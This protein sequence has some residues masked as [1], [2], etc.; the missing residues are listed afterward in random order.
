MSKKEITTIGYL[1]VSTLEQDIEKNKA[2]ILKL[3]NS[4]NLGQ[5]KFIEEKIS[6]KITWKDRKLYEVFISLKKG[7]NIIVSELSR[8]GRSMLECMEILSISSKQGINI[9]AVKGDWKLNNSIQSKIIAMA[10]AMAAEIE[11][12]LISQRTK[13]ALRAI[14]AAGK[15]LGR[16][17][18]IGK[19]KLDQYAPEIKALIANGST[20][21]FIAN[22]YNTTE[23]N[24][25]HWL[26]NHDIKKKRLIINKNISSKYNELIKLLEQLYSIIEKL[27]SITDSAIEDNY[28]RFKYSGYQIYI[29]HKPDKTPNGT[30]NIILNCYF[31][32]IEPSNVFFQFKFFKGK[33]WS[34]KAYMFNMY[35][36]NQD[37][38]FGGDILPEEILLIDNNIEKE[39]KIDNFFK[40]YFLKALEKEIHGIR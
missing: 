29:K 1:R 39:R 9:Y 19:S 22:R 30:P 33:F 32:K 2:D 10:F 3:A 20:Q 13:E 21:K 26:K 6:G 27:S 36:R 40:K 5:V 23:A 8:L 24:L 25:H 18:G 15:K 11:R 37:I 16:P 31:L 38:L 12:D 28:F 4:Y 35:S 14:K 7:D 34:E 17:K